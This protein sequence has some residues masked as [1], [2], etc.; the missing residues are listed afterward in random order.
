M[1][2]TATGPCVYYAVCSY[3]KV[4]SCLKWYARLSQQQPYLAPSGSVY[5][6]PRGKQGDRPTALRLVRLSMGMAMLLYD[7]SH[8]MTHFLDYDLNIRVYT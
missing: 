8:L 6:S 3:Y 7:E 2:V 1:S 4:Y 5:L